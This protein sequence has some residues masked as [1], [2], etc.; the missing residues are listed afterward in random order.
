[1]K[2]AFTLTLLFLVS[3]VGISF[4][5]P[6]CGFDQ[7]HQEKMKND[8]QYKKNILQQQEQ[9]KQYIQKNKSWLTAR[10]NSPQAPLYTIPVV[11]HVIHT[12][13][14]IG[15]IY[16]PTDAQIQNTIAYLVASL[17]L[18]GFVQ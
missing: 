16:N 18:Q 9:V 17:C 10:S 1:M 8:P 2:R 4:S 5:Q 3:F 13:G 6:R 12:G 15:T 7:I 14:A 11:V